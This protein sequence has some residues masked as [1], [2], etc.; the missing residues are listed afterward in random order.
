LNGAQI[1]EMS[2]LF[3][4]SA[5][6][7]AAL[8]ALAGRFMRRAAPRPGMR[9]VLR[10]PALAA[11]VSLA[12]MPVVLMVVSAL[13]QPSMLDR[14]GIVAAIAWAPLVALALTSLAA[15]ARV[16]AAGALALV[17]FINGQRLIAARSEFAAD[18]AA[19]SGAFEA[20]KSRQ[21]PLV[22]WG[23]HSIYPVAGPER[24]RDVPSPARY[25]DLPDSTLE[26]LF[27]GDAMEPVRK[28]YR[29]DRDQ[30]RGHARTY[31]FPVLATQTQLDTTA[32]FLLIAVEGSL[33][34]GYKRPEA[35][36]RA[37]FPA[38]RVLRVDGMLSLFERASR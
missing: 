37:V 35:F 38:H 9:T 4:L 30:A 29:L 17:L 16:A 13:L 11:M 3:W 26:S 22:F 34:G 31:G 5:V 10:D 32:R 2:K 20:A 27:P 1:L 18:V 6:P 8:A 33:P 25:L 7:L 19:L 23:L 36:G 21:V 24:L 15:T 14:Y 28:K 12:L